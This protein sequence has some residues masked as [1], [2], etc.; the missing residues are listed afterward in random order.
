MNNF[1]CRIANFEELNQRWDDLI[2]MHPRDNSWKKYKEDAIKHFNENS[3]IFYMGFLDGKAI[4]EV[5][6]HVDEKFD[7]VKNKE[8]LIGNKMAYLSAG[9]CDKEYED[10][11]YFGKLIRFVEKDLK[12]RSFEKLSLGVEPSEIRNIQ[13][14][15]H[16]GF[17]NY[18]KT[19]TE[20]YYA[21]REED[22]PIK[23]VVNYYYKEI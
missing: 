7:N 18:I 13:I 23:V 10:K 9:R 22:E 16:L 3:V 1:E 11:G 12:D 5:C 20:E 2:A 8:G 19:A 6:A 17:T 21:G 4:C 15:F 14:Y